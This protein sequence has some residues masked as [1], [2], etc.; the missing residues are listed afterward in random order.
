MS[1]DSPEVPHP[2]PER[3]NLRHLKGQAKDLV[4]SGGAIS[5]TD[6]QF[7]IARLYGFASWPKLKH[8][9]ESL[10][11][12]G[13][14]NQA[15]RTNDLARVQELLTANPELRQVL[16]DDVPFQWV[17][18][19]GRIPMMELLFRHGADVNGLRWGWFPAL[20]TACE[21]LDPEPLQWL[22]NHGA[23]PNR[24]N[25]KDP[26]TAL[27]Y[28]IKTYP[29][30]PDRLATCIEILLAAGAHTRYDVPGVLSILRG[31]TDELAGI[32]DADPA[33]IHCRYPGLDCGQ[34][35]GRLLTLRGA[36]LLHVA[37]EY[38]F[39]DATRL[40]LDRGADVNARAAIDSNGVGG[41]TPIF[42][43]LTHFK[44]M[45]PEVAQLLIDRGADLTVRARVPGH[46][47]RPGELL[48]VSAAEYAALF[49]LR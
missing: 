45:N 8:H 36:T 16:I 31:R 6:A 22:L 37:A 23:D 30:D 14:L 27:D 7:K 49:P 41:Q 46:Y 17:A 5:L 42:H 4:N 34:S 25:P 29:R 44:G 32:L 33:L 48:H 20:F 47:E 43:A 11:A 26:G 21:N 13:Q 38:G 35:G 15:I 12:A 3:A 24:G 2:L 19:Q 39:F 10:E 18:H 28:V 1:T 40:L 9:V